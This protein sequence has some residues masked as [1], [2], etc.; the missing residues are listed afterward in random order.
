MGEALYELL[1]RIAAMLNKDDKYVLSE[2]ARRFKE[3]DWY[4]LDHIPHKTDKFGNIKI[5]AEDLLY[6]NIKE[7]CHVMRL[8]SIIINSMI[9]FANK[10]MQ[11]N[12]NES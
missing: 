5:E 12:R 11:V 10:S 8:D 6:E 4:T 3:L 7:Y 2:V 1:Q 9:E